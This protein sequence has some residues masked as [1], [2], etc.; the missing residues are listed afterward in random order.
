[1]RRGIIYSDVINTVSETYAREILTKE[2]GENLDDLLKEVRTKLFGILNGVDY[3]TINP[4]TDKLIPFNFSVHNL[5]SRIKNKIH[6]QKEF[7]LEISERIPLLGMV[8]RL[9]EQK[10]ID[11]LFPCLETLVEE[12]NCQFV[13][14][15]GGSGKYH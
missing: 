11:L 12:F 8:G 2:Y 5:K 6:L 9:S 14:V 3:E 15:G 4:E 13:I 10:G 1:M 7:N